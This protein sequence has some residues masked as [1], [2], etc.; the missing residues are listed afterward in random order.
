M[1]DA[2]ARETAAQS[3]VE[4]HRRRSSG[5]DWWVVGA[6][7]AVVGVI[8]LVMMIDRSAHNWV[9]VEQLEASDKS[10]TQVDV[11]IGLC[12]PSEPVPPPRVIETRSEIRISVDVRATRG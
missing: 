3:T 8:A 9:E 10:A 5:R 4:S 12:D 7:I 2:V 6:C 1:A 11:T